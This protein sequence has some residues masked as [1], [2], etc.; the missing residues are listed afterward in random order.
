MKKRIITCIIIWLSFNINYCGFA[1]EWNWN[2]GYQGFFDNREYFN[3]YVPPQTMFGSR[4]SA[5]TGFSI[6]ESNEFGAG[7]HIL[8]EFGDQLNKD[9][10]Q[11]VLFFRHSSNFA[12]IILGT[13]PRHKLLDLPF[14]LLSD[15]LNYYR[16]NLEGIYLEFRQ[17]WGSH[18]LWLDWT[19]RQDNYVRETF[20]IGGTG[21][22]S[23]GKF[24]Y[25]HDF[26]MTHYAGPAIPILTD[27]IRDNGGLYS[28]IGIDFSNNTFFDTLVFQTGLCFSY[29]RLRNIYDLRTYFGSLSQ[30]TIEFRGFGLN[31]AS[32]FGDGQVQMN[33]D[34]LY[35]APVYNRFDF[36]WRVFRRENI[37]GKVQ[38]TMHLVEGVLD[39]SQSFTIYA[40]LCGSR[41]LQSAID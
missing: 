18:Q 25:R 41:K 28:G 15:T 34:G 19:S 1:Q 32:Y 37:Q 20:K 40:T 30:F 7:L 9:D 12:N 3:S 11:P 22:L 27:H 23:H 36:Y 4:L 31:T 29:D 39:M 10:I 2:T 14:F 17:S 6:N 26:V 24:F 16:P 35:A 21:K 33:G 38:F 8:Y 13:Y 5:F